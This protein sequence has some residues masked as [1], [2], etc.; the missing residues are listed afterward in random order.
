MKVLFWLMRARQKPDFCVRREALLD[1]RVPPEEVYD[2]WFVG[3][4]P[5]LATKPSPGPA[6]AVPGDG[7][8][9]RPVKGPRK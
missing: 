2:G 9:Q 8:R 4:E 6:A 1:L 7:V 5:P 3:D